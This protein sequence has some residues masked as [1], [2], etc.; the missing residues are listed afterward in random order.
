MVWG[1][2]VTGIDKDRPPLA[3]LLSTDM[4]WMTLHCLLRLRLVLSLVFGAVSLPAALPPSAFQ[5]DQD[6]AP[7]ALVVEVLSVKSEVT[8]DSTATTTQVKAR[9]RILEVKRTASGLKAGDE[10]AIAYTNVELKRDERVAGPSSYIPV[11][12]EGK[13]VPAYLSGT[14]KSGYSPAARIYSSQEI[15]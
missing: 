4:N 9:V 5:G 11:L 8:K 10:I 1:C 15:S 13:K 3:R 7:E 6:N 12:E 14:Q 2:K